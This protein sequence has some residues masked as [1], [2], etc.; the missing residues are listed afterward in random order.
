MAKVTG[1]LF[2]LSASG[3]IAKSLVFMKW[4]GID[5]VRK[6]VIP[7]NPN[8]T[9]QSAQ[10][11]ILK[12]GVTEWHGAAYNAADKTAWNL[13]ASIQSNVMSGFNSMIKTH[14]DLGITGNVWTRMYGGVI[15]GINTTEFSITVNK[16]AAGAIPK[17]WL[18]TSKTAMAYKDVFIDVGDGTWYCTPTGLVADT[19][20]YCTVRI[21][22]P[23]LQESRLGIY[24]VKTSAV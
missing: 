10:R 20:Y 21:T 15:T 23:A 16:I 18:G 9:L 11:V 22:L 4:K 5:D 1:P 3:Q 8:S 7:A 24:A 12:A 19:Q 13:F 14:V 2:S 17:L 6:Y